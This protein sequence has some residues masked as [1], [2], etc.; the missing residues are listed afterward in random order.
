MVFTSNTGLDTIQV[1]VLSS[2]LTIATIISAFFAPLVWNSLGQL[3]PQTLTANVL[4]WIM[5]ILGGLALITGSHHPR[6][7]V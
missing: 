5:L 1:N 4:I 2:Y 3:G 7:E 6:K